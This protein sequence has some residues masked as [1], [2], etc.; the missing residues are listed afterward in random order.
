MA[1]EARPGQFSLFK[2]DKKTTDKHPDYK[3]DGLDVEGN[4]I[5][6]SAWLK[7]GKNGKFLSCSMQAK[8]KQAPKPAPRPSAKHQEVFGDMDDSDGPF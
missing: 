5:W 7:S 6:V 2:N 3:G 4:P 8:E 1:Y